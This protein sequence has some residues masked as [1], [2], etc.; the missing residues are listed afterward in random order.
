MSEFVKIDKKI[1]KDPLTN[2]VPSNLEIEFKDGKYNIINKG[3]I[4]KSLESL[5]EADDFVNNYK[6]QN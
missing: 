6:K 3:Q 2:K 4:I 5:K 1:L